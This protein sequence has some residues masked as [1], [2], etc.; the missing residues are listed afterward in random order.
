M[1]HLYA[2]IRDQFVLEY[3]KPDNKLEIT[4]LLEIDQMVKDN[5]D[6]WVT[7]NVFGQT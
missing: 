2:I 3:Q 5:T 4:P 1:K 6:N 7:Q